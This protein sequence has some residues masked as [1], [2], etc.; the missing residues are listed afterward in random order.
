MGFLIAWTEYR[1]LVVFSIVFKI[2][3]NHFCYPHLESFKT[4][5]FVTPNFYYMYVCFWM[6]QTEIL[7]FAHKKNDVIRK[8]LVDKYAVQTL[9]TCLI[10]GE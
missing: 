8:F 10:C 4:P 6:C 9:Y 1:V 7:T 3:K 5:S 2:K